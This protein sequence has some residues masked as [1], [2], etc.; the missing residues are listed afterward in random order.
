MYFRF[1]EKTFKEALDI[2]FWA[3]T[4]TKNIKKFNTFF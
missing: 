3:P 4:V 1:A 2:L